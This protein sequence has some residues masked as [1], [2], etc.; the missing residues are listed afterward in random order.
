MIRFGYGMAHFPALRNEGRW[1][2]DRTRFIRML[3]DAVKTP[4]FLRPRRFGKSLWIS[5]LASYYDVA[6]AKDF[7]RLFGDL[8]IGRNPTPLHNQYFILRWDF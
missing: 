4:V 1:Y 2:V 8:D 6:Q 7:E 5:T 3:E